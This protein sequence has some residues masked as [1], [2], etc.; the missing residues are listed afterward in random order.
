[1]DP[2][3]ET[4]SRRFGRSLCQVSLSILDSARDLLPL[5]PILVSIASTI[6]HRAQLRQRIYNESRLVRATR[7][8][9][10]SPAE[11]SLHLTIWY[12]VIFIAGLNIYHFLRL[13]RS[14]LE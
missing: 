1:M 7:I 4:F 3:G 11:Y 12:A 14:R 5:Y 9:P 2:G 13:C 10:R 6:P 8:V